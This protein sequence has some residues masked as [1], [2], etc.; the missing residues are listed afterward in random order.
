LVGLPLGIAVIVLAKKV[1]ARI[2]AGLIDP[3]GRE[4]ATVAWMSLPKAWPDLP[5]RSKSA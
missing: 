1:L 3:D 2:D 4:P 5:T